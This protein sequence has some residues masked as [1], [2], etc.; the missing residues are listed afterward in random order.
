MSRAD[1][2]TSTNGQG[3]VHTLTM[4]GI[5]YI[6]A[7][8]RQN[9]SHGGCKHIIPFGTLMPPRGVKILN[10]SLWHQWILT[11]D[12]YGVR[13]MA[14]YSFT[15]KSQKEFSVIRASTQA[16]LIELALW[17]CAPQNKLCPLLRHQE[18]PKEVQR[19][20][21]IHPSAL[22]R[23]S[24]LDVCPSKQALVFARLI[25]TRRRIRSASLVFE[26]MAK[27]R[28]PG[29]LLFRRRVRKTIM[30]RGAAVFLLLSFT[31]TS[32]LAFPAGVRLCRR[33]K[34]FGNPSQI[35]IKLLRSGYLDD[36]Y[37]IDQP[38]VNRSLSALQDAMAEHEAELAVPGPLQ[39]VQER[40]AEGGRAVSPTRAF[41]TDV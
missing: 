26:I 15:R 5:S 11:Y 28:P 40:H 23:I 6:S 21:R 1:F 7:N 4:Q 10:P 8:G 39:D 32:L 18:S 14:L 27:R 12:P 34:R 31:F 41:L 38:I 24:A 29:G 3:E 16:H 13:P 2:S 33:D 22:D 19:D 9:V 20:P 30:P 35:L 17:M 37:A 36:S 25:V